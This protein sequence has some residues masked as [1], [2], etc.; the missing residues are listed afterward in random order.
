MTKASATPSAPDSSHVAADLP[1]S[2]EAAMQELDSLVRS[3]EAGELPLDHLLTAYQRGA[4]LLQ[5]CRDQLQAAEL[6][7]GWLKAESAHIP[8]EAG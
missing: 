8:A 1:R 3:M 4:V 2:Y 6:R 7:A 5:F